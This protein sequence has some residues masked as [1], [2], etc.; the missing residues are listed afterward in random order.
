MTNGD[1]SPE[2]KKQEMEKLLEDASA[3][4]SHRWVTRPGSVYER[5]LL[6][7][8]SFNKN[9][10]LLIICHS[11]RWTGVKKKKWLF[12]S[13]RSGPVIGYGAP[14]LFNSAQETLFIQNWQFS[15][16]AFLVHPLWWL[17]QYNNVTALLPV[18]WSLFYVS[19]LKTLFSS[20]ALMLN[21]L[22]A[23]TFTSVF[24]RVGWSHTHTHTPFSVYCT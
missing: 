5:D 17:V 3:G 11:V 20:S 21:S 19:A 7:H 23:L 6:I 22:S 2:E 9:S 1:V 24:V 13:I 8:Y 12:M 18:N 4:E 15:L 14:V 16:T 10:C